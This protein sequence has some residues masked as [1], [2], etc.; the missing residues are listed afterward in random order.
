MRYNELRKSR[1]LYF[2]RCRNTNDRAFTILD[3]FKD[4]LILLPLDYEILLYEL[5]LTKKNSS[6]NAAVLSFCLNSLYNHFSS[7]FFLLISVLKNPAL[8]LLFFFRY[9]GSLYWNP[10]D[11]VS[12]CS[13]VQSYIFIPIGALPRYASILD[14]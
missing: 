7:A 9:S 11:G 5:Y 14:A 4:R 12:T 1:C 3:I 13:D 8:S 10:V 6:Y 2:Y